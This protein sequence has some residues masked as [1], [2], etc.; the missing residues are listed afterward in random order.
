M[1]K[2]TCEDRH[3]ALLVT[4]RLRDH[5]IRAEATKPGRLRGRRAWEVYAL[6]TRSRVGEVLSG[7]G[8]MRGAILEELVDVS[9][10]IDAGTA[11]EVDIA[12]LTDY[13]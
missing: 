7:S 4:E 10:L 1:T 11:G 13:T 6:A 3:H 5:G 8:L 12:S 2:I 9:E